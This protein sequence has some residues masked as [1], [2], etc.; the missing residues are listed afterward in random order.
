MEKNIVIS[1]LKDNKKQVIKFNL[2]YNLGSYGTPRGLYL[3]IK[4]VIRQYHQNNLVTE[5]WSHGSGLTFLV[6]KL[7][8]KS[9]K[10]EAAVAKMIDPEVMNI[11]NL[12]QQNK[13]EE[14]KQLVYKITSPHE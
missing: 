3:S 5:S 2:S 4:S 1:E 14:I 6:K 11:V 10:Q 8:R 7:T 13:K 12:F 9:S